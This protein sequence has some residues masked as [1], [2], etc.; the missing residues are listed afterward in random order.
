MKFGIWADE[1]HRQYERLLHAKKNV[2]VGMMD[3]AVGTTAALKEDGWEIHKKTSKILGLTPASITNQVVQRDNHVE[4][5][6]VLANI[7]T[8][9]DKIGVEIRSLQRTEIME[10]GEF[11]DP[12]KQVGSSTMPHK[13]NPITAERICGISRIIRSYVVAAMENNPLWHERDLTNSSC[14]RIMFPEACILTD[15][16]LNLTIK[17]MNN[18][19][20]YEENI[21]KNLNLTNGL[22]M[23]ERMMAELTRKGM[24]KLTAYGI[25]RECAIK[26]NKEDKLLSDLILANEDASKYLTEKDI[27]E[28]MD[29]H[30]YLGSTSIIIDELL[31]SSKNWF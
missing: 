26:A 7:A 21:E 8:T 22:I 10:V 23:A 12:E 28:I 16:I 18:L 29:P 19:V 25:V 15:Y 30:T 9:L 2:C 24:G 5:I 27:E 1:L 4:F 17:L 6:M 20:F 11:F 13:M 31:E 3:G 14:E